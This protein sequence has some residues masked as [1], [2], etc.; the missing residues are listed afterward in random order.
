VKIDDAM[1]CV[2]GVA[3][4]ERTKRLRV[5]TGNKRNGWSVMY[6]KVIAD[7]HELVAIADEGCGATPAKLKKLMDRIS[8]LSEVLDI[9]LNCTGMS[10]SKISKYIK[11]TAKKFLSTCAWQDQKGT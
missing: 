1:K 7:V 9:T 8:K 5:N 11:H 2:V 6:A 4:E 3:C 10:Q